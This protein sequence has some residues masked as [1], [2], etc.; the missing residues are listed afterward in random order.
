MTEL[1][2]AALGAGAVLGA[3]LVLFLP[4]RVAAAVRAVLGDRLEGLDRGQERIDRAVREE[5][6]KN[7]EESAA[8]A[9]RLRDELRGAHKDAADATVK[10][11]GLFGDRLDALAQALDARLS[12]LT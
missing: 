8:A 3:A 9:G 4:G 12:G 1:V 5:L 6:G 11:L 10:G 2:L 7:R